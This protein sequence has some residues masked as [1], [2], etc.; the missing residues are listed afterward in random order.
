MVETGRLNGDDGGSPAGGTAMTMMTQ[1]EHGNAALDDG[2][3]DHDALD[4][5]TSGS[6]VWGL[7]NSHLL[8]W[9]N[10]GTR[11]PY[12]RTR[13]AAERM[14]PLAQRQYP[15]GVWAVR[16]YPQDVALA[17]SV[18]DPPGGSDDE[19]DDEQAADRHRRDQAQADEASSAQRRTEPDEVTR[20]SMSSFPSSD[21]P[22]WSS[23]QG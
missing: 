18:T 16:P 14:I 6:T 23:R 5:D 13:A 17:G 12:F 21:P 3:L 20:Q 4:H 7:W 15:R 10:P 1:G 11:K 8:G 19:Q 9:F 2:T 22:S